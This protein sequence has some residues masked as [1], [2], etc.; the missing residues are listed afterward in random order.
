MAVKNA[1]KKSPRHHLNYVRGSYL[2]ATSRPLYA[3]LFL[4]PLMVVY[5]LGTI[6]VNTD[7]IAHTQARVAAFTWLMAVAEWAGVHRNFACMFP[8]IVVG[9][10]LICWHVAARHPWQVRWRWLAAMAVECLILTAPLFLLGA[11]MN[12]PNHAA[13]IRVA[14]TITAPAATHVE[15]PPYFVAG[16]SAQTPS[17]PTR[18]PY[19]AN[20]VI[21]IG[22]GIYEELVFRLILMGLLI[23]LL[24]D[25]IKLKTS[26]AIIIAVILSAVLFAAH[27][28]IGVEGGHIARLKD[29]LTAGSFLF[30]TLAGIYFAAV[31]WYRGYGVSAGAHAAYNILY[32][33]LKTVWA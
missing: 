32:F 13:G 17:A 27:H 4:A 9:I 19:L 22:A 12:T 10:I 15:S 24:E 6:L 16:Q 33:A 23:M 5:E 7:Q 11:L 30:R 3:L 25:V 8:G 28:Y 14:N 26:P 2:E 20:L 1:A 31:F 29:E 21:S 18:Q